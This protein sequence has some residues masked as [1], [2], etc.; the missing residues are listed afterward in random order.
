VDACL[1]YVREGDSLVLTRLNWL[2]RSTQ[3]LCQIAAELVRDQVYRQV[4]GQNIDTSDKTGLLFFNMLGVVPKF[5]TD[6]RAER[7]K[8]GI[9]KVK[10]C[11]VKFGKRR[12][13]TAEHD[14]EIQCNREQ[15]VIIKTFV[16]DYDLSKTSLYNYLNETARAPSTAY[17]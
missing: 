3:H 1:E 13:F 4:F 15:G 12:K 2:A 9:L 10:E 7:N 5:E 17:S 11:S 16:R 14:A 6:R 8:E